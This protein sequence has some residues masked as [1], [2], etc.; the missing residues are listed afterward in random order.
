[1]S[2]FEVNP[3]L[4]CKDDGC[5]SGLKSMQEPGKARLRDSVAMFCIAIQNT[6]SWYL[7]ARRGTNRSLWIGLRQYAL[8]LVGR[9]KPHITQ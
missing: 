2:G 1:M 5:D 9:K 6:Q 8:P 3:L 4:G 7:L